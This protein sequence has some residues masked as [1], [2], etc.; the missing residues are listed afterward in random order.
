MGTGMGGHNLMKK[1]K[2][3]ALANMA[4]YENFNLNR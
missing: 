4:K 2:A 1:V 3:H